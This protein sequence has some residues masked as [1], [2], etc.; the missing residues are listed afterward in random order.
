DH[1][2]GV[3]VFL[4]VFVSAGH[5]IVLRQRRKHRLTVRSTSFP[6]GHKTRLRFAQ[7]MCASHND[8]AAYAANEVMLRIN[9]I[10]T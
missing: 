10:P 1:A 9:D 3:V 4:V 7:T 8:V 5:N 6:L 2:K